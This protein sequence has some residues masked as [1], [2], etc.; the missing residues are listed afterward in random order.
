[1][2][3][4]NRKK[5]NASDLKGVIRKFEGFAELL[6]LTVVYYFTSASFRQISIMRAFVI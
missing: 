3:E 2:E 5:I 1:M 6:V 4:H